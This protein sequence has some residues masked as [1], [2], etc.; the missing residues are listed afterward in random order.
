[1]NYARIEEGIVKEIIPAFDE[2]FPN[3]PI[4]ERFHESII[5]QLITIPEGI[6]VEQYWIY[7]AINGFIKPE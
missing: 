5:A 7:D 3:I 1:M 4:E 2:T 6:E